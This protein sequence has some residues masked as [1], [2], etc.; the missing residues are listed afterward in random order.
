VSAITAVLFDYS[1]VLTTFPFLSLDPELLD[2]FWGDY[3]DVDANHAWHQL[4]RGEISL[5]EFWNDLSARGRDAM[6][7]K[8]DP[9]V[10]MNAL[11]EGF[12]VNFPVVHRARSL[13]GRYKTALLTN[14]VKEFGDGW[15]QTI[16]VDELFDVVVDS[17]EVGARKPEPRFFAVALERVGVGAQEAVFLDDMAANVAGAEAV[18]IKGILVTSVDQALRD[19]EAVLS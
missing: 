17:C 4:E 3:G 2:L 13:R 14:N 10:Y 5:G 18:G 9:S 16:P 6:G 8:F 15:R 11:R 12:V 19:L 7:D 1:G